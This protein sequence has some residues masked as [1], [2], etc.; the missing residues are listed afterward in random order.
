M[1]QPRPMPAIDVPCENCQETISVKAPVMRDLL[2]QFA[3]DDEIRSAERNARAN[4]YVMAIAWAD[5]GFECPVC[6]TRGH[7][8]EFPGSN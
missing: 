5:G 2:R 6:T 1:K 3:D 7:V 8:A 4:G